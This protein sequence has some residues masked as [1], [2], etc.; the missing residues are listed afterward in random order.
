MGQLANAVRQ[1]VSYAHAKRLGLLKYGKVSKQRKA[2]EGCAHSCQPLRQAVCMASA[3]SAGHCQIST[4]RSK[5]AA[6][7]LRA[8]PFVHKEADGPSCSPSVAPSKASMLSMLLGRASCV[9]LL[10]LSCCCPGWGPD[11]TQRTARHPRDEAVN[12]TDVG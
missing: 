2:A 10:L 3:G 8:V 11:A 1:R 4:H 7:G 5:H 9:S 6:D 12:K